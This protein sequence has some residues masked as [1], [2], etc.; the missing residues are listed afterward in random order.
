MEI[1]KNTLLNYTLR[2]KFL[3]FKFVIIKGRKR[4]WLSVR[5][6]L[7]V[8]ICN[9]YDSTLA[10]LVIQFNFSSIL[11]ASLPTSNN[12]SVTY[13]VLIYLPCLPP[14]LLHPLRLFWVQISMGRAVPVFTS[15][16]VE[17]LL[18]KF[19]TSV[20][21]G[22]DGVPNLSLINCKCYL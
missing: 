4:H 10:I 1:Q 15:S 9:C 12:I 14:R 13:I 21:L 7:L 22:P 6:L 5:A 2:K 18:D 17:F 20:G 19:D 3:S 16:F 8:M 11:L